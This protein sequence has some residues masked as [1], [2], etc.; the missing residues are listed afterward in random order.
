M[1]AAYLAETRWL[2]LASFTAFY[3]AQ[4][5]PIGLLTI[6]VPAWLAEHGASLAEIASY[7]GI[8]GL[9]WGFKLFAGPFMDRFAF[10]PMGRR[11]PWVIGAQSGL[12]LSMASLVFVGDPADQVVL[13][14]AIGFMVNLFASVQDVAVDGMA[15]D[16]LPAT[17]RGRA[18]ALMAF[19]Q[20]A[21]FSSFAALSGWL[22]NVRGLPAAA[23]AGTVTIAAVLLL[24]TLTRERR[25][26]RILPWSPGEAARREHVAE[27]T[28]AG[29]FANLL[30]VLF[31]PM[32]LVLFFCEFLI[33]IRDGVA[34]SVVPVFAVQTLGISSV[35]Y[36]QFQ[37]YMGVPI[38]IIGVLFGPLIDR[39]GIKR[40]Y[41]LAI[42]ISALATL[43]FALTPASWPNTA[44]VV[45]IWVIVALSGQMLFVSFIALS[46]NICWSRV[47]ATQ[48]AIYMSLSNL[49]RSIGAAAFSLVAA[50]LDQADAFLLIG[51]LM[52][53]AGVTLSFFDL[54]S[55]QR[56]LRELDEP[57]IADP[58]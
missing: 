19:G 10:A 9:P 51:A 2:R 28:F 39:F 49:S 40:L 45:T 38:A 34:I 53:A 14:A 41:L 37:G 13:L 27:S 55:H 11:R 32:S 54:D 4:G 46:M 3:Y 33:R 22:L 1:I 7:Q 17:E 18:N 26:E 15:I 47:A 30:R 42:G 12:T 24:I 23:V 21:G 6:A 35:H 48:F 58:T 52:I 44:Y 29:I 50:R 8:V 56:R 36:S 20:V 31:L 25:G 5:V 57:A 43:T 16:V